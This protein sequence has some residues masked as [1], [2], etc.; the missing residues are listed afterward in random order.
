MPG[1]SRGR[2]RV[3]RGKEFA[4]V[5]KRA[6]G[7]RAEAPHEALRAEEPHEAL[8]PEALR[9]QALLLPERA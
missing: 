5:E 4:S 7:K 9:P 1:R 3:D 8:R 2:S 6:G